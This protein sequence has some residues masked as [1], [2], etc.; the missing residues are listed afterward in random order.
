[1]FEPRKWLTYWHAHPYSSLSSRHLRLHCCW[2]R[3]SADAPLDSVARFSLQCSVSCGVGTQRRKQV[4]Q[5]LTA[6]GRRAPL[7]EMT[8]RHLPRPP[9]VRSCQMPVCSGKYEKSVPLRTCRFCS[10]CPDGFIFRIATCF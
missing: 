6:K 4:C 10:S 2:L 3:L 8:C 1:M 9:L 7:S 5:R